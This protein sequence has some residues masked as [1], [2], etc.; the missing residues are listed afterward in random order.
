MGMRKRVGIEALVQFQ[1]SRKIMAFSCDWTAQPAT[2]S[3]VCPKSSPKS[4]FLSCVVADTLL[5]FLFQH[6]ESDIENIL[7]FC[8][9][10]VFFM[11]QVDTI[12]DVAKHD[13]H[14]SSCNS[15]EWIC[16]LTAYP[17]AWKGVNSFRSDKSQCSPEHVDVSEKRIRNGVWSDWLL[18]W[19]SLES[20]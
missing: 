12:Q 10:Q 5:V 9:G 19:A 6:L 18:Q 4:S 16:L 13:L 7:I 3:L 8:P 15:Y 17:P 14:L 11:P 1:N 20:G 2:Q